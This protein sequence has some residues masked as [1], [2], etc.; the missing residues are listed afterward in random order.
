M[1]FRIFRS[2]DEVPSDFGPSVLTIGNFDGVHAGHRRILHR[3]SELAAARGWKPSV[4]TFDPHP[5]KIVAPE[6]APRLM[7]TPGQRCAAM[8]DEGIEQALIL[9]FNAD[10]ARMTPERFVEEVLVKK[11][12]ARAVLV[13]ED[14]RFGHKHA[15]NTRLLQQMG[16]RL[17][18]VTEIVPAV[19]VR[20]ERVS[21]SA[22]RQL[23]QSG[24][25]ARACR[26]LTRPF[27]LEG[28]VVRGHGVGAKQTVPTLNLATTS[29]IV[30][31]TGVYVT[32]TR[33]LDG[34]RTWTSVTN[35]GH[36]PTF[37]G[38]SQLSI[39]TFLLSGIEGATPHRIAVEFLWRLRE[40][41][42]FES[43]EALKSQILKDAGRAKSYFRRLHARRRPQNQQVELLPLK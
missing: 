7:T 1:S 23:V 40:E 22:V 4:L 13:G 19:W 17:G 33:D 42:K 34:A 2:L 26:L 35:V 29:E 14:F 39:E 31:A 32:R 21:S 24:K 43:P 38:D 25:V 16:E 27:S 18:F 15:G 37:G 30:P 11:L 41:K 6:R 20:G 28:E 3:V 36:R 8:R 9:P 5:A 12:R 10:V